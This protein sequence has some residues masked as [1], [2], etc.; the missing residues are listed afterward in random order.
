[1]TKRKSKYKRFFGGHSSSAK[2]SQHEDQPTGLQEG[3]E[4]NSTDEVPDDDAEI[5]VHKTARRDEPIMGYRIKKFFRD[6]WHTIIITIVLAGISYVAFGFRVDIAI[7]R[8]RSGNILDSVKNT[9]DKMTDILNKQYEVHKTSE[10]NN[11]LL[12]DIKKG[13]DREKVK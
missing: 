8:E 9:S 13:I 4:F 10:I 6:Y 5:E 1:M 2:Q 12:K 3:P 7:L 11:Y